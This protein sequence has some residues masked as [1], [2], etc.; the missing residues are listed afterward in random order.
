[1]VAFINLRY[2]LFDMTL[3]LMFL[4]LKC[5]RLLLLLCV[6]VFFADSNDFVCVLWFGIQAIFG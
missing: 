1:M 2:G 6:F 3:L 4:C 5:I